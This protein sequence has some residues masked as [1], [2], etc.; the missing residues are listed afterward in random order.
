MQQ[1]KQYT[2]FNINFIPKKFGLNNLGNTCYFNSFLQALLS[3]SSFNE[4]LIINFKNA[5]PKYINNPLLTNIY[6]L[7][8]NSFNNNINNN[9]KIAYK[10]LNEISNYDKKGGNKIKLIKHNANDS[11]DVLSLFFNYLSDLKLDYLLSL[12]KHRQRRYIYCTKVNNNYE[13]NVIENN[14]FFLAQEEFSKSKMS[15]VEYLMEYDELILGNK[16]RICNEKHP[17]KNIIRITLVPEIIIIR[18][19]RY[20][21][22]NFIFKK[23]PEEFKIP[24]LKKGIYHTYKAISH[25]ERRGNHY[26]TICKRKSGWTL[27]NDSNVSKKNFNLSP[28]TY[29]V[30]YHLI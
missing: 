20:K 15:F 5:N 2:K 13:S 6:Y 16:C 25:I 24:V 9:T 18:I 7:L 1:K 27:L 8:Q 4:H 19:N 3:C 11:D 29:L 17:S 26:Y 30:F 14:V 22:K 10:I 21:K 23:I 12:F 28:F